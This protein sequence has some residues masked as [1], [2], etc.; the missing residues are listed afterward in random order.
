MKNNFTRILFC[1]CF[2][3]LSTLAY[4]EECTDR[5]AKVQLIKDSCDYKR[6]TPLP[7]LES[8]QCKLT[9]KLVSTTCIESK[10]VLMHESIRRYKQGSTLVGLS[11]HIETKENAMYKMPIRCMTKNTCKWVAGPG[12]FMRANLVQ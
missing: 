11:Y 2:V 7:S 5:N 8:C 10:K 3:C 1:C 12:P 4:S 9:F 6:C